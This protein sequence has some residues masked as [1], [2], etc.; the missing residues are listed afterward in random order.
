MGRSL[1][2]DIVMVESRACA[3]KRLLGRREHHCARVQMPTCCV[4]RGGGGT[5]AGNEGGDRAETGSR[6]PLRALSAK[7]PIPWSLSSHGE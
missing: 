2:T 3:R 1:G 4:G 5:A 7:L 6:G